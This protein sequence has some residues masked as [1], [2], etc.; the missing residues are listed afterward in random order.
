MWEYWTI[1]T[2]KGKREKRQPIGDFTFF[3]GVF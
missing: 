2:I 1:G 3:C